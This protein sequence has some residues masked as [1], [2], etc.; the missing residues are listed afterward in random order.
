LLIS[1]ITRE[2]FI[3]GENEVYG[4][5]VQGL[6]EHKHEG[7][8]QWISSSDFSGYHEEIHEGHNIAGAPQRHSPVA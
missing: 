7:H 3:G 2:I 5:H 1:T 8:V 6:L 4:L